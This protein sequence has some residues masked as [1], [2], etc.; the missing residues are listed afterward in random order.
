MCVSV[1]WTGWMCWGSEM[2]SD[3]A[4]H[5]D[6]GTGRRVGD[7]IPL[8]AARSSRLPRPGHRWQGC[9][10]DVCLC[11]ISVVRRKDTTRQGYRGSEGEELR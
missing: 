9:G 11:A 10:H 6:L 3:G 5:D 2:L 1:V 4:W 8:G 7:A